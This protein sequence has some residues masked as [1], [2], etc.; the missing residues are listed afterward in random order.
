MR[1]IKKTVI[2]YLVLIT[3]YITANAQTGSR[4]GTTGASFL[5]FGFNSAGNAMGEAQVSLGE[6]LSALYWNPAALAF[7]TRNE[8]QITYLPWI[9]DINS[10]YVGAGFVSRNL[11]TFA[12][13]FFITSYGEEQVTTVARQDG[14]GEV[15]DGQDIAVAF[16]YG[17][18]LA[19]WF[20]FGASAKYIHS[21]IWHETANAVAVDLGAVVNTWFFNWTDKPGDGLNIGMSISNYGTKMRYDGIDLKETV[22]IDP[23]AE[24]NYAFLPARF[25]TAGWELP[26]IARIGVSVCPLVTSKHRITVASDFLHANNNNEYV[27]FG[28][29]YSLTYPTYGAFSIRAGYKGIE[30][31][32][33]EYGLTLGFGIKLNYLGNKSLKIDYSF[34]DV[35][36]LGGMHTY[37]VGFL[38]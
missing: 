19:Q 13:S 31:E 1:Y 2:L 30:M 38:F 14:T 26:L 20:S 16:S 8:I 22:D 29:Q 37:S 32:D 7:M 28:A 3:C 11:G 17:R 5:E 18:K 9:L 33:S 24:G 25:E 12:L 4:V 36:L 27:N 15:Y 21:Q 6:D 23:N 35:G 34:R 10:S